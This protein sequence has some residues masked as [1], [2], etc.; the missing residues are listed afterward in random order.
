M[1]F[2]EKFPLQAEMSELETVFRSLW[3]EHPDLGLDLPHRQEY[4]TEI[5]KLADKRTSHPFPSLLLNTRLD[6]ASFFRENFDT[7]LYRHLRYLP[8]ILHSHAFLEIVCVAEGSC[9]NYVQQQEL[10]MKKGDICIIAPETEHAVSAFSD[11]CILINIL[12]RVSTFEKAF[13]GVL[14]ENDILSDFFMRTLYHSKTH[15][16]LYFRTGDDQ[17]L[18]DYVLYA[19]QEFLGNHQYKE[20]FLNNII[21]AFFIILL[22]NH[23]SDVIVPEIDT[24]GNDENVIFI[25]K[26][27]QENYS[28][29]TLSSLAEFFNYSERQI[30]RIIKKSTGISF[31]E[32]IQKLKMKHAAQLLMDPDRSVSAVAEDLGYSDVGNFRHIFKKYYGMSP[33]EYRSRT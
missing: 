8:A 13:F 2:R 29:V 25:L 4:Y 9:T 22:R 3:K 33:A 17:E 16:Y 20:R 15:P 7:E 18:F 19:Y 26:Y 11:E 5:L 14:S 27:M 24:E 28:T 6:E 23:G 1:I 12:L 21:S 31:S 30:Q 10:H 32:N